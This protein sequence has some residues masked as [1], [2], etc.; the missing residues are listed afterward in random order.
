MA[1]TRV[2]PSGEMARPSMPLLATRPTRVAGDL[3]VAQRRQVRDREFRRQREG[4]QALAGDAAE[5]I[6]VRA[7]LVGDEDAEAVVRHA[8]AFGIEAPVARIASTTARRRSRRSGRR[9]SARGGCRARARR[10]DAEPSP[11]RRRAACGCRAAWCA[12][13]SGVS[14]KGSA[15]PG[16][17]SSCMWMVWKRLMYERGVVDGGVVRHGVRAAIGDRDEA[18]PS[19]VGDARAEAAEQVAGDAVLERG[20]RCRASDRRRCRAGCRRR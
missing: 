7:V 17:A 4:A 12:R 14:T 15:P 10:A 11:G 9:S 5:L 1:P 18:A 20:R 3:V 13:A 16:S 2:R 6:E 19:G 8:H